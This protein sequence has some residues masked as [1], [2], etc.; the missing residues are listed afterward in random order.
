MHPFAVGEGHDP[1]GTF[2]QQKCFAVRRKM[3]AEGVIMEDALPK[4]KPTRIPGYDY[5]RVNYYFVTICTHEKQCLFYK[6]GRLNEMGII[7]Q[8]CMKEIP[9]HF[10]GCRI[11]KFVVMPNHVHAILVIDGA[12]STTATA[13]IG[14][15]KASVSR[16]IHQFS[17]DL[18]IWQRSFHDHIIRT[19]KGY[20]KIWSYIDTNPMRWR[21]DCFYPEGVIL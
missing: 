11:D 20:E 5:S 3:C 15:Y 19:Q 21:E 2:A 14:Q 16:L 9:Q 4:R 7:A 6:E 10:P 12:G 8:T 17:P 18:A 13:I 1:P